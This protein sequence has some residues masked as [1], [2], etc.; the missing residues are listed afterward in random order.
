VVTGT[1]SDTGHVGSLSAPEAPSPPEGRRR[2][3]I[4]FLT[5]EFEV[6]SPAG[7]GL[8]GYVGRMARALID[9]GHE[10]EVFTLSRRAASVAMVDGIRVEHLR[11][12]RLWLLD[13]ALAAAGI[14]S[15]RYVHETARL[16]RGARS[17]GRAF[18][19]RHR[20]RRFDF[21]Q[22]S[23]YGFTGLFVPR[24]IGIPHVL[25]CSWAADLF[26][27]LDGRRGTND[28]F[29]AWLERRCIARADVAYAPSSCVA[30]YLRR[31]HGLDVRTLRPPRPT[32]APE[33]IELPADL[34]RRYLMYVGLVTPRKGT[35][36]LAATLPMVWRSAADFTMVWAGTESVRGEL[37]RYRS[38]W[39]DQ[40]AMVHW[41][42]AVPR[43]LLHRIL[44]DAIATVVASRA[45]NLPNAA[46]ESL[47]LGVAVIGSRGASVDEIV[48]PHCGEIVP[49]DDPRSLA[50]AL[51]RAWRGEASW[52]R[53]GFRPPSLFDEMQPSRAA[54]NLIA[55]AT[56]RP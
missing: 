34:P 17:I 31:R 56:G 8:A 6:E 26:L 4:A 15:R 44:R 35:D 22:S 2:L 29:V 7:G 37:A 9:I 25:R 14:A 53:D 48:E 28:R 13:G 40:A 20:E 41:L 32:L 12:G 55:L 23:D 54:A 47:S 39:G 30:G 43:P 46:L 21:V 36:L 19:R 16:L 33:T 5:P 52:Q 3:R 27:A 18:R 45:D 1:P 42:G 10:V 50:D 51:L 11:D 49:A 24:R 38:L